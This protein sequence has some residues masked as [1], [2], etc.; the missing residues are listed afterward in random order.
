MN[1]GDNQEVCAV[2]F[3][4]GTLGNAVQ[5]NVFSADVSATGMF[6]VSVCLLHHHSLD[7]ST[8]SSMYLQYTARHNTTGY[9]VI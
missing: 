2:L 4:T 8:L 1:E 6:Q 5:V 3:G 7:R 9:V